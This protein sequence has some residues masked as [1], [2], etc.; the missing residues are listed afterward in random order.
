MKSQDKYV[1]KD[2]NGNV[3]CVLMDIDCLKESIRQ[4]KEQCEADGGTWERQ[5]E[6]PQAVQYDWCE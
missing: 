2:R 1:F 5:D 6:K 3:Y 4:E